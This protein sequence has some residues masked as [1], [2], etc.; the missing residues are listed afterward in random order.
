MKSV[1]F[2]VEARLLGAARLDGEAVF[3]RGVNS[4]VLA[5]APASDRSELHDP[6][7]STITKPSSPMP[8][9]SFCESNHPSS[10]PLVN[11]LGSLVGEWSNELLVEHEHHVEDG[12]DDE[13]VERPLD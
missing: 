5:N 4:N 9:G 3:L 10:A 1:C 13:V 2:L 7:M 12:I 6:M 8:M 11:A